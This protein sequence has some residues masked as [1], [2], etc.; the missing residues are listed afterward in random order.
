MVNSSENLPDLENSD[1]FESDDSENE[2]IADSE[3]LT[4]CLFCEKMC[5]NTLKA[6]EHLGST[7][8]FDLRKLKE[9]FQMDQYDFIKVSFHSSLM[10]SL[11]NSNS[12]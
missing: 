10:L 4:K 12:F 9:R 6:V 8:N 1:S 11:N 3:E 2:E 5:F 7:H